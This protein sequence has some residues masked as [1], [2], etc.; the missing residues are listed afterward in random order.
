MCIRDSIISNI[1][2][3]GK[4]VKREKVLMDYSL[5]NVSK[6]YGIGE[7]KKEHIKTKVEILSELATKVNGFMKRL[8]K[9]KA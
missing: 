6:A 9:E 1:Y 3:V 5:K 8:E 4:Y 2:S 7:K